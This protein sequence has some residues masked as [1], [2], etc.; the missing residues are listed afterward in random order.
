MTFCLPIVRRDGSISF[1]KSWENK[2]CRKH[3]EVS[4]FAPPDVVILLLMTDSWG[5]LGTGHANAGVTWR[6]CKVQAKPGA[7]G[8]IT[9]VPAWAEVVSPIAQELNS[10]KKSYTWSGLPILGPFVLSSQK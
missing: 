9:S 3:H 2:I 7:G 5:H 8:K 6:C 1:A 4:P 10:V